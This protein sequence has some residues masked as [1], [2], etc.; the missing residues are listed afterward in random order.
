M[1][2]AADLDGKAHAA[3]ALLEEVGHTHAP[4]VFTTSFGAE[5]MVVF[6]LLG[7]DLRSIVIATLD[8]GRLPEQTYAVWQRAEER[9]NRKVEAVF[10]RHEAVEQYIRINGVNAFYDSVAQRKQCCHI[11][12]VEPLQRLLAGK[13]A[14]ITGLRRAQAASRAG[15]GVAEWDETHQLH[16]FNPLADWSEQEVW[17]YLRSR[18]VPYNA[19]HDEGYPSIGC[20]PC[21]RAIGPGEDVRAGRWWWE[22][23]EGKECGLHVREVV[24]T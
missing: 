22:A 19:L 16:K 4:A 14:W 20:A 17:G 7:R 6:D 13:G 10:P 8:T 9:Y 11:R 15:L 2:A 5:D 3:R 24:G 23:A 18:D 1:S 12:K 21:T